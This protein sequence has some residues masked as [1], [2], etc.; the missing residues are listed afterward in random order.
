MPLPSSP[1][2][3]QKLKMAIGEITNCMLRMDSEREAMK[4]IIDDAAK[5]FEIDKKQIRRIATTM[6]KHNYEDIIQEHEEF[7]LLYETV[8]EGRKGEKE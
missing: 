8:I 4:E 1:D 6:Y 2:E 5:S 3:R 7:E